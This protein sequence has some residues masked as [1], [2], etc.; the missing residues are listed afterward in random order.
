MLYLWDG[1]S[2]KLLGVVSVVPGEELVGCRQAVGT[3]W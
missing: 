1:V 2:V 3:M